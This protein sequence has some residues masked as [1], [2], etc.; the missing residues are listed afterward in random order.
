MIK[1]QVAA[2]K[3]SFSLATGEVSIL[4]DNDKS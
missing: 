1:R 2:I 3:V 4:I